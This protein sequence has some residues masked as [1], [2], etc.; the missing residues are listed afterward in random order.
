MHNGTLLRRS[1]LW[2]RGTM[3]FYR[4]RLRK[5]MPRST[6]QEERPQRLAQEEAMPPQTG[7]ATCYV[8]LAV[9]HD[10]ITVQPS[11]VAMTYG[12]SVF[13]LAF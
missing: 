1:T 2:R 9:T 4:V 3:P 7:T 11:P 5:R 12:R 6:E 10:Q 8:H 13:I